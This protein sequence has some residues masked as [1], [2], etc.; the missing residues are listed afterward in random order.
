MKLVVFFLLPLHLCCAQNEIKFDAEQRMLTI[1]MSENCQ[2]NSEYALA[3]T[4]K[5]S[6]FISKENDFIYFISEF[7]LYGYYPYE[8]EISI[9][10]FKCPEEKFMLNETIKIPSKSALEISLEESLLSISN[11][12]L[13]LNIDLK[14]VTVEKFKDFK[15]QLETIFQ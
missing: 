5:Y 14:E 3:F 13:D 1:Q 7:R 9:L 2:F 12:E 11:F 8:Y 6:Y 10:V 15:R 4:N